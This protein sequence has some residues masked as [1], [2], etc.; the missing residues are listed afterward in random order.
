MSLLIEI[1]YISISYCACIGPHSTVLA[2]C[3]G[4]LLMTKPRPI[5]AKKCMK[6]GGKMP[7]NILK[8]RG[9]NYGQRMGRVINLQTVPTDIA[10]IF[11][12]I[13][14]V[15]K[16]EFCNSNLIRNSKYELPV[17]KMELACRCVFSPCW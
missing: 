15:P 4:A 9:V 8:V 1:F 6:E 10:E 7:I 13:S 5:T 14:A 2:S 12:A 16:L 3:L 11:C 17:K